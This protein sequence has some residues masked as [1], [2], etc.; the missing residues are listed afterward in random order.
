MRKKRIKGV[1]LILFALSALAGCSSPCN[2]NY[3]QAQAEKDLP[4]MVTASIR[5]RA[6]TIPNAASY[7]C[8][9]VTLTR[10]SGDDY[11]GVAHF[12]NGKTCNLHVTA[13]GRSYFLDVERP[14]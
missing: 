13:D 11:T 8:D 5:R 9:K 7:T 3:I 2:K 10:Q 14:S 12:T 6:A 1:G 4:R